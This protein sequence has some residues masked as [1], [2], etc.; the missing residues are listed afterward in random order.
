LKYRW[1]SS[2]TL[3]FASKG[4]QSITEMMDA[5]PLRKP[6]TYIRFG[7]AEWACA[8][9]TG[10]GAAKDNKTSAD[11]CDKL[12]EDL[13]DFG[14]RPSAKN[15]DAW[16]LF[17]GVGAG[18]LCKETNPKLHS[19]V[20]DFLRKKEKNVQDKFNGWLDSFY[21]P[22]VPSKETAGVFMDRAAPLLNGRK[23]V[24]VGPEHILDLE[25]L[26]HR[27]DH[28]AMHSDPLKRKISSHKFWAAQR[29]VYDKILSASHAHPNDNVV[30]L[31]AGGIPAKLLMYKAYRTIGH[32]DTIIDLGASLDIFTGNG[33]QEWNQDTGK[34]CRDYPHYVEGKVCVEASRRHM[35]ME[36]K[37]DKAHGKN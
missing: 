28:I 34:I 7:D 4:A 29:E 1:K 5:P 30:F 32:K 2:R 35:Q 9:G 13:Q 12:L 14:S 33:Q 20:D 23:V 25:R 3:G 31:V 27:V 19:D 6:F 22:L 18:Y 21:L 10:S 8:L 24:T 17:V 11:I 15:R 36:A 26:T 37:E 16:N